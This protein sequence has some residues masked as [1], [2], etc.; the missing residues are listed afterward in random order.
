[1]HLN[2]QTNHAKARRLA[3]ALQRMLCTLVIAAPLGTPSAQEVIKLNG[4]LVSGGE[5]SSSTVS[6]D[7]RAVVYRAEQN[8]LGMLELFS[9][10]IDGGPPTQLNG[11]VF[12]G[13][14]VKG[15]FEITADGGR[16]IFRANH[17][18]TNRTE[19]YSVPIGG[20]P[21]TTLNDPLP[22]G[23]GVFGF[24][25]TPDGSRVVYSGEQDTDGISELYSVS[26]L[27]GVV[28]KISGPMTN[29]GDILNTRAI[30]ADSSRVIY[31]ADQDTDAVNE[32]YSVS[33]N[34]GPV[35]KL[36]EPLPTNGD[37]AVLGIAISPDCSTAIYLADQDTN[38]VT[39]L[40]S[41]PID[42]GPVTKISGPMVNGGNVGQFIISPDS[43][44]VVYRADQNTI[45]FNELF[46]VPLLG[47]PVTRLSDPAEGEM[48]NFLINVDSHTVVYQISG[49]QSEVFSVPI[50]GGP[51][52][53]LNAPLPQDHSVGGMLLSADGRTVV[54]TSGPISNVPGASA[55]TRGGGGQSPPDAL[56]SV[57]IEGGPVTKLTEP[58]TP[59]QG[60]GGV[61]IAPNSAFVMYQAD[62]DNPGLDDVYGVPI[63]GGASIRLN[64]DL[65]PGGRVKQFTL[66][67]DSNRLV[68]TA[69]QDTV[70]IDEL[71]STPMTEL[72]DTDRIFRHGFESP[73]PQ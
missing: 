6:P 46:S 25:L 40:Y 26:V 34:G 64:A 23:G 17:P 28:T 58:F 61:D 16:V 30:S 18:T 15:D 66:S 57:P 49:S 43:N 55:N 2:Q 70:G 59:G 32:L 65:V 42:G 35:T 10:P 3:S 56:F 19:L 29:G 5:V 48:F 31:L 45:G 67:P 7:S 73:Q 24:D 11:P 33:V 14:D 47:G 52:T 37:V 38:N 44:R 36:N 51:V 50:G 9:V 20:G 12:P 68:Y 54:F 4:S 27:G 22:A 53:Q 21:V 69:D 41:V 39:E 60:L 62:R 1:M 72:I 71:Y 13:S 8:T 63:G